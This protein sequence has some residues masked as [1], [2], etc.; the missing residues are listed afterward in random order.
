M[1]A[2]KGINEKTERVAAFL[3][4]TTG[5]LEPSQGVKSGKRSLKFEVLSLRALSGLF[6]LGTA[7]SLIL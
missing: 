4:N 7:K 6:A 5:L 2:I 3:N 1:R